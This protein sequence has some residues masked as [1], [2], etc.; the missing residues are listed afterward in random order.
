MM[1]AKKTEKQ[2]TQICEHEQ[3]LIAQKDFVIHQ[4]EHHFEI[5]KGDDISHI[6]SQFL[7]N[8]KTEKV[9]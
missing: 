2:V 4:N 7:K 1:K 5:K 3:L 8:L 9:I 6:P